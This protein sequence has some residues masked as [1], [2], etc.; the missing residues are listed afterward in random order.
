MLIE[1]NTLHRKIT[2]VVQVRTYRTVVIQMLWNA[3][4][5][6]EINCS[7]V[8]TIQVTYKCLQ[9]QAIGAIVRWHGMLG[10]AGTQRCRVCRWLPWTT[11]N[12]D[13]WGWEPTKSKRR[14]V[15]ASR[16]CQI[17]K[18]KFLAFDIIWISFLFMQLQSGASLQF[19]LTKRLGQT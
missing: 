8:T 18:E 9:T 10:A 12:R 11:C 15:F 5:P 13:G 19:I 1:T 16:L 7:K 6:K 4:M 3:K 17:R 14:L 2:S